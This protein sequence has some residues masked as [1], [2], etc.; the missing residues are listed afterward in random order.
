[1]CRFRLPPFKGKCEIIMNK[2]VHTTTSVACGL[3]G[4]VTQVKQPFVCPPARNCQAFLENA[5][6]SK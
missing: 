4:A 6:P 2:A 3:A 5:N 1:M